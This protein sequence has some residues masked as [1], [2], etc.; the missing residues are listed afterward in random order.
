MSK[1]HDQ[2]SDADLWKEST[3]F[4]RKAARYLCISKTEAISDYIVENLGVI[5]DKDVPPDG[6]CIIPRTIDGG[7]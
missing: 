4:G 7:A 5:G 6:Y 3:F 2:D 1:T